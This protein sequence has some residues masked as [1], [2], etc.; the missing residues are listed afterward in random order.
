MLDDAV[1]IEVNGASSNGSHMYPIMALLRYRLDKFQAALLCALHEGLRAA[2]LHRC[3]R[4]MTALVS[5]LRETLCRHLFGQH[6]SLDMQSAE[7]GID[8]CSIL[9]LHN[10]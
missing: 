3:A 5:H 4:G 1:T 8:S 9:V 7:T 2:Q 6:Y 10:P